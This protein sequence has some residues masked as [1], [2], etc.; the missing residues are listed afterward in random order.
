MQNNTIPFQTVQTKDINKVENL[1]AIKVGIRDEYIPEK[2]EPEYLDLRKSKLNEEYTRDHS[3]DVKQATNY[4]LNGG[5]YHQELNAIHKSVKPYIHEANTSNAQDNYIH[6]VLKRGKPNGETIAHLHD[7]IHDSSYSSYDEKRHIRQKK[8][9]MSQLSFNS[10]V[11]GYFK[12]KK[13]DIFLK[14]TQQKV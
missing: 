12:M 14:H 5:D 10:R 6:E 2:K 11:F 9:K 7:V 4:L 8:L 3:D 1:P 13:L